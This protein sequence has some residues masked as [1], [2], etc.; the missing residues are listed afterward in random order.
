MLYICHG[1]CKLTMP[2]Q[3]KIPAL[4]LDVVSY[5]IEL[6][7]LPTLSRFAATSVVA[8]KLVTRELDI[9]HR[10]ILAPF[11]K[12][13]EAFRNKLTTLNSV[14][15][16]SAA[17]SL[18][19]ARDAFLPNDLDIYV[20]V[21]MAEV[22]VQYLTTEEGYHVLGRMNT[23]DDP[24]TK[25]HGGVGPIVTVAR[26]TVTIDIVESN[27]ICATLPIPFFWT[28]T[29]MV[30]ITGTGVVALFPHLLEERRGL[31]NPERKLNLAYEPMSD[32][33][34]TEEYEFGKLVTKYRSRGHDIRV[35]YLDWAR[36][37]DPTATCNA[38]DAPACPLT[39]R[40]VGDWHTLARAFGPVDVRMTRRVMEGLLAEITTIWR[41]GG[42]PC[43]KPCTS[44]NMFV[45]TEIW[46][47]G[48]DLVA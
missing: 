1:Q 11:I 8:D 23:G 44:L 15:S 2:I 5:I 34:H 32:E 45:S 48:R 31:L 12:D 17:V 14:L 36:E 9:R 22:W 16:G 43:G 26:D 3:S 7:T 28:T 10:H 25:Y 13:K 29:A 6:C 18:C 38:R 30:F 40:W 35:S 4:P 41:L 19:T 21:N 39:F 37:T 20:P 46:C 47:Q 27:T 33:G 24:Y 42:R